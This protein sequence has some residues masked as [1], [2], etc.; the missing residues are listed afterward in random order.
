MSTCRV[1]AKGAQ[2]R[3]V[4]AEGGVRAEKMWVQR[5]GQCRGEVSAPA[6]FSSVVHKSDPVLSLRS[7][8][9]M[10]K[11][12]ESSPGVRMAVAQS[13]ALVS[14]GAGQRMA[15]AA[16]SSSCWCSSRLHPWGLNLSPE[17]PSS[18]KKQGRIL[19]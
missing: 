7:L 8:F 13:Q 3:G 2:N 4:N 12:R 19:P 16:N 14:S 18:R 11:T 9:Q 15:L 6:A 1:R 10:N 17:T 5:G